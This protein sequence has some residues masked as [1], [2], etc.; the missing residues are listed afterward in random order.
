[1][2]AFEA[3]G[4]AII[5]RGDG[6]TL[7]VEPWGENSI[8]LRARRGGALQD[9]RHALLDPPAS[10][11]TIQL[12][13]GAACLTNGSLVCRL[14]ATQE[15]D[16]GLGYHVSHCHVR[17]ERPDGLPLL[18]EAQA[19]SATKLQAREFRPLPGGSWQVNA[20]FAGQPQERLYGMGQYQQDIFDLKGTTLELAH[21]NSQVSLPVVISS[22]GYGFMWHNPAVGRATF[23]TNQTLWQAEASDQL[24]YWV[25][26]AVGPRQIASQLADAIGHATAMPEWA[27]G[28]WQSKL[29][30]ANQAQLL[31]V[32]REHQRRGL[33][34]AAIAADFF[35]WPKLGE[36]NFDAEF[37]PDPAAMVAELSA[38]GCE[39]VVSVW[40][41][42][43]T[44]AS[45]F[46]PFQAANLLVSTDRGFLPQMAFE[47]NAAFV[48][49]TNPAARQA[50]WR[51]IQANYHR[52]GVRAFWLDEAEPEYA[53]Y[54]WDNHTYFAGPGAQVTN[55]YPKAFAQAFFEGQTAAGQDQIL[56][57]AR[58]AW[59]GSQR[60]GVLLWSG[61]TQSTWQD[62]R[63]QITA[64]LHTGL[65][66]LPYVTT[67]I[68]GFTGGHG[69]D[70]AFLELLARWFEWGTFC[71]V[72][73]L[74]GNRL[75]W[76]EVA[77]NDGSARLGSGAANEIWS[78]GPEL[79]AIM[80]R[81]IKLRQAMRPYLLA[82]MD[83]AHRHGWPVM[84]PL[85][86]EFPDDP[87]AWQSTH[88]FM[89][90]SGLLVAPVVEPGAKR[91]LTYLPTGARWT[92][93][94]TG[95]DYAA[96]QWVEAPA[97]PDR[98]PVFRRDQA[99]PELAQAVRQWPGG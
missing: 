5:W 86:F 63:R 78:F 73:R 77:A 92:D 58:C 44:D 84:R 3:S 74:H 29:R 95:Q 28:F 55:L 64:G 96:G 35:H 68:G 11:A 87:T 98:I 80:T 7:Q 81:H 14:T 34:L 38:M 6:E 61:N 88:Q 31:A 90:G 82:V 25:T 56:N 24:D 70:P 18:E 39:L 36:F 51:L 30:Y 40:P 16:G 13:E 65:A 27:L 21:R 46:V 17:F 15:L 23:A 94:Y 37:W 54:Q 32:A 85:F 72:M 83:Q 89:L 33:P 66:G 67:D 50:V 52:I 57:L 2:G 42:V 97:P 59:L 8:R 49:F 22:L 41:H 45:T 60:F 12:T 62:L 99:C 4:Q 26:A 69:D 75:P 76:Q 48:D 91:R 1:L 53:L 47:G 20:A 93:L 71:P 79:E 10:H 19:G 43:A 9:H